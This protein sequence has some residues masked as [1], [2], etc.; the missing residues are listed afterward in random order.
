MYIRVCPNQ[1]RRAIRVRLPKQLNKKWAKY[2][3]DANPKQQYKYSVTLA[4]RQANSTPDHFLNCWNKY[5]RRAKDKG[6]QHFLK[7]VYQRFCDA[8]FTNTKGGNSESKLSFVHA[9]LQGDDPEPPQVLSYECY[10][11]WW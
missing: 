1:D 3:H 7:D 9:I 11:S 5:K 2:I 10:V 4:V 8:D 6:K